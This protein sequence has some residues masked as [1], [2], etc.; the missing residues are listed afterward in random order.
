LPVEG[1]VAV[2]ELLLPLAPVAGSLQ[3]PEKTDRVKVVVVAR[4]LLEEVGD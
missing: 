4:K 2:R 3:L 1:E